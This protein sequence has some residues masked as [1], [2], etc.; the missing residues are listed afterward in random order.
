MLKKLQAI[1]Q[2][3]ATDARM[4]IKQPALERV[5]AA[6]LIQLARVDQHVDNAELQVVEKYV[7]QAF[8]VDGA[9]LTEL[10][11]AAA[12]EAESATSLYEFT[13]HINEICSPQDKYSIILNLWRV[14]YADGQLDKYEEHF[15]RRAA[16]L[17]YVPHAEFIRAKLEAQEQA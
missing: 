15:V 6:L 17:I 7:R 3:L 13:S 9:E 1:F 8:H 4:P 16:E 11:E 2:E 14:A 5:T 10:M 12:K